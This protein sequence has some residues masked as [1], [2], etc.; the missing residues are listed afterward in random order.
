MPV[1]LNL[2]P[3]KYDVG[4]VDPLSLQYLL[5]HTQIAAKESSIA[6]QQ[7]QAL[8]IAVGTPQDQKILRRRSTITRELNNLDLCAEFLA[9]I[10]GIIDT[11]KGNLTIRSSGLRNIVNSP[12]SILPESVLR[13]I[14]Y[15]LAETS[16]EPI[17]IH[18]RPM[19]ISRLL[20]DAPS[21]HQISQVCGTWRVTATTQRALWSRLTDAMAPDLCRTWITRSNGALLTLDL[22]ARI[23]H[24]MSRLPN[25]PTYAQL[26]ARHSE[27]ARTIV[28]LNAPEV[29]NRIANVHLMCKTARADQQRQNTFVQ[30]PNLTVLT[31]PV[32][33]DVVSRFPA[34][35]MLT[36]R[37]HEGDL[38]TGSLST[39]LSVFKFPNLKTLTL[40]RIALEPLPVAPLP[41][42]ERLTLETVDNEWPALLG[43]LVMCPG[44][45]QLSFRGSDFHPKIWPEW[46]HPPVLLA[47]L[48]KL[49]FE[50]T[51]PLLE[52]VS[53]LSMPMLQSL[54]LSYCDPYNEVAAHAG[55][56]QLVS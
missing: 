29:V 37:H 12:I 35:E 52:L 14:F 19:F 44:L 20:T 9:Q 10:Q 3:F 51:V 23:P 34:L 40:N 43:M 22:D 11:T 45:K 21:I 8:D 15:Y 25:Y 41:N 26:S 30:S 31:A 50:R 42:L 2:V 46:D 16:P 24:P 5:Q 55:A 1:Q 27:L 38:G 18:S 28:A 4:G 39:E 33:F 6:S 13:R 49:T 47:Q 48:E 7:L 54:R 53:N 36:V 32:L 17:E 56:E